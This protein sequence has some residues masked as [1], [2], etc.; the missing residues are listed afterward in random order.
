[1]RKLTVEEFIKRG[2]AK[3]PQY[4]FSKAN[5]I[6]S[7]TKVCIIC[8]KHGEF[9]IRPN[10]LISG[11]GCPICGGT[12]KTTKSDYIKKANYV[13]NN[14]FNYE[15]CNFKTVND[16]IIVTCP[17][18]GDFTI[19]ANNHLAGQ[20]CPVC[21]KKKIKHNICLL[22][23]RNAS[24][25]RL[26][27]EEFVEK[28][29]KIHGEKYSYENTVYIKSNQK[30]NVTCP[31]HGNFLVT[32]NHLLSG[33]G[34]PQCGKNYQLTTEEFVEKAKKIHGEKY[35]Y[36]NAE[37]KTTHERLIITCL[38][39]GNFLQSPANHLTG[40]GCP[41]CQESR[42]EEKMALLLTKENILFER[43][44]SFPW[45]K[46][47]KSLL[48]DFYLPE[49]NIAI[50]CQGIQHFQPVEFFGSEVAYE[51]ATQR[52]KVKYELCK[53]NGIRILYFSDKVY[54]FFEKIYTEDNDILEEIKKL[55]K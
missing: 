29:K 24:T 19:K 32:P 35:S 54:N 34:C 30:V 16:K 43:Q 21:A 20:G 9:W 45:L 51:E 33:R 6:N 4:D 17:L 1:M 14:F 36:E 27:T 53:E 10:D 5:Y 41:L 40:K 42:L 28:A 46:N 25:K 3:F 7:K 12:N 52:D 44:R 49:R 26:T 8:P 13:H 47:K 55:G 37:Y 50:E 23:K 39:H 48:L 18:H 11:I 38:I 31:L 15:K 22:P 2:E